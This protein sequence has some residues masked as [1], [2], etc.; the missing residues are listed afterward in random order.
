L[1]VSYFT[2]YP[3]PV[4]GILN[5]K[6]MTTAAERTAIDIYDITGRIMITKIVNLSTGDQ[7]IQLDMSGLQ[8]GSYTLKFMLGGKTTSQMINKF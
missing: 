1:P 7:N 2:I 8:K 5:V 3:N 4:Q 6:V